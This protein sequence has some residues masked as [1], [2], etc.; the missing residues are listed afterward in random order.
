MSATG[1]ARPAT[2]AAM[3]PSFRCEHLWPRDADSRVLGPFIYCKGLLD[4]IQLSRAVFVNRPD[5]TS[6]TVKVPAT[7]NPPLLPR[8]LAKDNC[9]V[10]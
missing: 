2:T 6:S 9:E 8:E 7:C 4:T 3:L 10:R 5:D 1:L